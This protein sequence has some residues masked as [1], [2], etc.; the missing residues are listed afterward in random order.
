M[1]VDPAVIPGLLLLAAELLT[2]SAVGYVVARVAL[3]QTDDRLALAQGLV[4]GLALWGLSVNFLL[5]L[6]PGMAGALAGWLLVLALGAGLAWRQSHLLRIPPRTVARLAVAALAVFWAVLASRQLMPIGDAELH[7]GLA[8]AIRAGSYPP[9]FPWQPDVPAPYHYGVNLLVALLAPPFGPNAAFTTEVIDAFIWTSFALV[10]TAMVLQS[11][12]WVA[13]VSTCPLL[14]SFG[15][16]T[17]VPYAAPPG[18]VEIPVPSGIPE[19]GLRASLLDIYWPSAPTSWTAAV[20]ASP[21]NI[22]RPNFVLTYALVFVVLE[23]ASAQH[24]WQPAVH[25]TLAFVVAFLGLLDEFV[26]VIVLA[27]WTFL[28]AFRLLRDLHLDVF[29]RRTRWESIAHGPLRWNQVLGAFGGPGLAAALL[30]AGG[31]VLTSILTGTFDSGA[32]LAWISDSG[33]RRPIAELTFWPGGVGMLAVGTVPVAATSIALGQR[34][35]L[36]VVLALAST[37]LLLAALTLRYEFSDMDVARLDGHA[38]NFALAA[39][40]VGLGTRLP[41]LSPRWRYTV[42]VLIIVTIAWPT[43]IGPA[44]NV[45]VAISQGPE[46][47]NSQLM[48]PETSARSPSYL[49]RRYEMPTRMSA[50][51]AAYIREQTPVNTRI[52]SP[53]PSSLSIVTGRPNAAGFLGTIQ[54]HSEQGPEYRDAIRFL[55]PLALQQLG[56]DHI[57]AP[58]AWVA[59]LPVRA[60]HWLRNPELFELLIS[61]DTETLHRVLPTFYDL[62]STPAPES[63][64]AL[65]RS[66]PTGS[67]V[68][69]SAVLEPRDAIRVATVLAHTRVLGRKIRPTWHTRL[70]VD[71][72]PLGDQVPDLVVTPLH[73]APSAFPPSA[74]R[75]IWWNKSLA[76]YAPGRAI[77]PVMPPPSQQFTVQ[78]DDLNVTEG[79]ITFGAEFANRARKHWTGQDWLVLPADASPWAI[80][81]EAAPNR[82]SHEATSWFAGQM[83]PGLEKLTHIYEYDARA[84]TLAV[85]DGESFERVRASGP[86]L[87]PGSYTLAVRL[88]W[89]YREA[90][91]IPVMSIGVSPSGEVTYRVYR[92]PL[93]A[94]LRTWDEAP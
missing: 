52:L 64:E 12:S 43:A 73:R 77:D 55:E 84:G 57:H 40:L 81:R 94:P 4:I 51:V 23:R 41:D 16:W 32:S 8:A 36:V 31:G 74:R 2:L 10:L 88:Q 27:L 90:A 67:L 53:Y 30:V 47:S 22:W 24:R 68:Y 56:I 19:A 76:V 33:S 9:T 35:R 72:E 63:F 13:A 49:G 29:L 78:V 75:P 34:N 82:T 65:R 14:L 15:L 92:G 11:G 69:F 37:L 91:L 26:A 79:R 86:R 3:R 1:T 87:D 42:G 38:R 83:T 61:D 6:F 59:S 20:E 80:P 50:S 17:Q 93:A 48:A 62:N 25:L 44:Q 85:G 5:Y 45:R 21:P 70:V 39:L 89:Q 71:M 18:I 66:V 46:L 54:F 7:L 58:K 60:Q 28:E